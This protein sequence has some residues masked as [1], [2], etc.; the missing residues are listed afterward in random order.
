MAFNNYYQTTK[1]INGVTYTAQFNGLS[2]RDE[3]LDSCHIDGGDNM[4]LEKLA[5][6]LFDKVLIEPKVSIDTFGAD[7]IGT[8]KEKIING[9]KYVAKFN[10]VKAALRAI[11]NCYI[12]GTSATS[13]KKLR[14]YLFENVITVPEKLEVD[15]F[16]T[17]EELD[18]V[19]TFAREAMQ[20][21]EAMNEFNAVLAFLR[22]T[23]EGKLGNFRTEN[24]ST[25]KKTGKK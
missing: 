25:T 1:E 5:N 10:G 13:I 8:T 23:M 4:S 22:E 16:E 24:T 6:A 9:T 19:T 7:K 17:A 3:T 11:D 12:D 2:F 18:E 20:D 21:K 15:S 14:E